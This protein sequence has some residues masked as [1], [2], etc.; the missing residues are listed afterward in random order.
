MAGLT[1]AGSGSGSR[2]RRCLRDSSRTASGAGSGIGGGVTDDAWANA[3]KHYDDD[4]LAAIV[5]Q[6]AIINAFNR[7]NVILR[8]PAGDYQTGQFG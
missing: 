4:Q 2:C 7:L 6:I 3:T 8:P 1:C 5:S